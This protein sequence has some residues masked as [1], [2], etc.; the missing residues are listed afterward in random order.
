MAIADGKFSAE[1]EGDV[2]FPWA[3]DSNHG[4]VLNSL[5]FITETKIE[6]VKLIRQ[7]QTRSRALTACTLFHYPVA[8]HSSVH[9]HTH[10]EGDNGFFKLCSSWASTLY[11]TDMQ[12]ALL[13]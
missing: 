1:M 6:D 7:K 2:S 5:N 12:V 10:S 9:T 11:L 4:S 3:Q 8:G 13:K